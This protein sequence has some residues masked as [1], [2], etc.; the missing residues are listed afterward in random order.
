MA[1]DSPLGQGTQAGD[2]SGPQ[3]PRSHQAEKTPAHNPLHAPS[4]ADSPALDFGAPAGA[5]GQGLDPKA[6]VPGGCPFISTW[7]M[8]TGLDKKLAEGWG[9]GKY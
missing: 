5:G 7:G 4:L 1:K 8:G 2:Y 6:T 9:A 3:R